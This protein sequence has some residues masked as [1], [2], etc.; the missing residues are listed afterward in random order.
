V[1]FIKVVT[2][3]EFAF[4]H[5]LQVSLWLTLAEILQ[6]TFLCWVQQM[7]LNVHCYFQIQLP[8]F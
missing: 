4:V 8:T 2:C 7:Q 3:V 5:G 1:V 6:H